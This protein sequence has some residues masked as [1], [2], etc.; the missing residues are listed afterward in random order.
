MQQLIREVHAI[1]SE[2]KE[3]IGQRMNEFSSFS[4]KSPEEW[5]SEL[6]FCLLTANSRAKT[7]MTIQKELGF[8]GFYSLKQ[9]KLVECIKRNKHRFHNTKAARIVEARKYSDIK[10]VI[11]NIV[12]EEGQKSARDWLVK[13][14]KGLGYKEASH[15]L[16]N[17]GHENLAIIDRHILSILGEHNLIQN[18]LKASPKN[19]LEIESACQSLAKSLNMS[20][21]KL[22]LSLWYIKT[23]T[24]LK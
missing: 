19:Y 21:S 18:T 23:G 6:C 11:Q 3:V 4:H 2:I 20:L 10:S 17:T 13:N 5:F 14:V 8:K 24:V 15:F 9:E 7:A 1:P 12:K 16:R 22:D